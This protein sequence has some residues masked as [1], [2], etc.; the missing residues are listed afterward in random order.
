M[1]KFIGFDIDNKKTVAC[2]VQKGQK[3]R[4][5]TLPSTVQA[6]RKFLQHEKE[7]GHPVHLTF[8]ISGQAGFLY[9]ELLPHVDSI[10]VSNPSTGC[11]LHIEKTPSKRHLRTDG[12]SFPTADTSSSAAISKPT[13]WNRSCY[14][15]MSLCTTRAH[16]MKERIQRERGTISPW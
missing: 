8:E 1:D 10:T 9:D 11:K 15:R 6:M 5:A 16:R 12:S 13:G 4:F 14:A 3:D 2:V 7:E